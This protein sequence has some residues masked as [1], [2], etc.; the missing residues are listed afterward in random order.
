M[1]LQENISR[2]KQVMKLNEERDSIADGE[3]LE[4]ILNKQMPKK[5]PWWK[6][7]DIESLEFYESTNVFGR[8]A[9]QTI[10]I[11]GSL[12]VDSVWAYKEWEYLINNPDYLNKLQ[13]IN[14]VDDDDL[15]EISDKIKEYYQ[16]IDG[17]D[18]KKVKYSHL[19]VKL[20]T[21]DS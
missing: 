8:K 4:K 16:I 11:H 10:I 13:L 9:N 3:V 21:T 17:T 12:Y 18:I 1:N 19:L 7:I 14:L 5:Y 20:V 6:H 15:S 2:I